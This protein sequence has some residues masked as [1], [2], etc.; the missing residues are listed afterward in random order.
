MAAVLVL[1][2]IFVRRSNLPEVNQEEEAAE[3][4]A[5]DKYGRTSVFGIPYLM[6]GVLSIFLYVGVEV[7]AIDS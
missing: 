7:L 1:L 6:L 5:A 4:G 2:A 3:V